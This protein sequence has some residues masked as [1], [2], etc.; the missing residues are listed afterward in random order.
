MAPSL[1][2]TPPPPRITS[3]YTTLTT[4]LVSGFFAQAGFFRSKKITGVFLLEN[5][6]Q[7]HDFTTHL[8]SRVF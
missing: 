1:A 7:L 6:L 8:A 2:A 4:H 5:T 3:N